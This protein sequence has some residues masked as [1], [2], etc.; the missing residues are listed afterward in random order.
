MKE[1]IEPLAD[2]FVK[3]EIALYATTGDEQEPV[4]LKYEIVYR[5]GSLPTVANLS[6]FKGVGASD[7]AFSI[8]AIE[9][10]LF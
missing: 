4:T 7:L 2:L 10:S 8:D 9:E 1:E 6:T 5:F 3:N